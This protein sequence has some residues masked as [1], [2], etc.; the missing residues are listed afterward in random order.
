VAA[1]QV[2]ALATLAALVA[3]TSGC[4]TQGPT[5]YAWG[6][7]EDLIYVTQAKPGALTPEAQ[8]DQLQKDRQTALG[9]N[10]R[11]PPGWH[12]Q[13]AALYQQTGR[14]D[15]AREELLAEKSA[16]PEAATFVDRLLGNMAAS[17]VKTP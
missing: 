16:F 7:Y 5:L 15:L 2:G 4:A 3:L 6:S 11:L 12:V 9:Q 13:L 8:I 10:K 1:R 17:G 14:M